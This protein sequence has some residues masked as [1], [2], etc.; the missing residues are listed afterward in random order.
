MQN[1]I[2]RKASLND[3]SSLTEI[4]NHYILNTHITFDILPFSPEER[5]PWFNDH[6]DGRRYQLLVAD[7]VLLG[8]VGYACTGR[9]RLKEGQIYT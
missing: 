2:V 8:V 3:L 5:R 1:V 7:D 6:S 4:Q 9:F